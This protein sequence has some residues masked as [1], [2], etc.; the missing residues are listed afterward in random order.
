MYLFLLY[1]IGSTLLGLAWYWFGLSKSNCDCES[2]SD[3]EAVKRADE[4]DRRLHELN[5]WQQ[6]LF[7]IF[8]SLFGLPLTVYA[9]GALLVALVMP[10]QHS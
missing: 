9:V 5:S 1:M 2:C 7:A 6:F 10:A 4:L 3:P 8:L